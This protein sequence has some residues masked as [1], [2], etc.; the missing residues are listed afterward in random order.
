M[1][2]T[3]EN[4]HDAHNLILTNTGWEQ[5]LECKKFF[6]KNKTLDPKEYDCIRLEVAE[7]WLR[8]HDLGV[9]PY[10][11][12]LAERLNCNEIARILAENKDLIEITK[13]VFVDLKIKDIMTSNYALYLFDKNGVLLS[14][15]GEKIKLISADYP[16]SSIVGQVW[17]EA[18]VGTCA[19]VLSM[20]LKKPVYIVGPEH[21]CTVFQNS[22]TS[23]APLTNED[24][25]IIGYLV[26]S[27]HIDFPLS[28]DSYYLSTY[29]LGLIT[30]MAVA[31]ENKLRFT[32]S[33]Q[34][35]KSAHH[36]QE[37]ILSV[38]EEGII[39]TDNRGKIITINKEVVNIFNTAEEEIIGKTID[40]FLGPQIGEA[41]RNN[42]TI[43]I[44]EAR[45]SNN[46]DKSYLVLIRPLD[47]HG[48]YPN[49][50]VL[51]VNPMEMIN[52]L[53]TNRT[54]AFATYTFAKIIGKSKAIK[55]TISLG[56][57]F[58]L[59]NENILLTGESGTGKELFAQAIHNAH[60]PQGPFIAVN[61]AAM[62]R[63]LIE[64]E[65]F[66]YEGGSFTGAERRGRAGKIELAHGGTLFLDEI[67]DMP[68]EVQAILL[69]VL[70]DKKVMRIGGHTYKK[71]DFRL[72]AAT[73]KDLERMSHENLFRSD[74]FFRLS[75]LSIQLPPLRKRDNDVEVLA[76]YFIGKYCAKIKRKAPLISEEA[77][78]VL[79]SYGWPGNV[80]QLENSVIYA[81]NLAQGDLIQ[82]RHLP[83]SLYAASSSPAENYRDPPGM[84]G[85]YTLENIYKIDVME[86]ILIENALYKTRNN[87][88]K[89]S[90]LLGMAKSTLYRKAKEL[91]I[92]MGTFK[93]S[94]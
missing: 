55:E 25:E 69:R 7:S 6:L 58:S 5:L 93:N 15:E 56:K 63:E 13:A 12:S 88:T 85:S 53:V 78:E 32:K 83:E 22:C 43:D 36:M 65:L 29:P 90:E 11:S 1:P 23:A 26:V 66:G 59:S 72:V 16:E 67:G 91:N 76:N 14:H 61:C 45:C 87:I 74:L 19:H 33:Y 28:H 50:A 10:K 92:D 35:L 71:V 62:P 70:E 24:N 57:R 31:V 47:K 37:V 79:K 9:N 41:V 86:K 64:S 30:A 52:A 18:T 82:C 68:L 73:N 80:R 17:S 75:I 21:Y 48:N 34:L 77:L 42:E 84:T 40:R 49:G 20:H 27:Y 89:A 44:E 2:D 94:D 51:R 81:V 46:Q 38:I 60:R 39:I 3:K 54:G 4:L 8:S